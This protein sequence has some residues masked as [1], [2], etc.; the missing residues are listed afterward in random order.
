MTAHFA[1]QGILGTVPVCIFLGSLLYVDSYKLV[2]LSRVLQL[3]AAGGAA[4]ALSY[5]INRQIL[6]GAL[7]DR[8]MLTRFVAPAIEEALKFLP[9]LLMLRSKRLGFVID[10][11]ICGF[12]A[13]AGFAVIENLYYLSA[14]SGRGI[15]FWIVRGF[16]T[17]VMH[18]GTTAIAAMLTKTLQQRRESDSIV[19]AL[20][21][22]LLAF[23]IHALFNQ[24]YLSPLVSAVV[25]ILVLPPLMVLLF[26]V[27]ERH[28]Q[29]WIGTGFDRDAALLEAIRSD[30]FASSRHGRYLQSLREHFDGPVVADM[31]CYLRLYSELS[32]RAKGVLMLRENGLPVLPDA[33]TG[34]KLAELRYLRAAI[35]RTGQLAISPLLHRRDEDLW[36]LELLD[37]PS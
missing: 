6:E 32:I 15:P 29:A 8:Q 33:A 11:A 7:A 23:T 34:A 37:S 30:D 3:I 28:L 2:R 17:A 22:L 27:S 25:V 35:G 9:L 14:I 13:G 26:A 5:L 31:L 16:G 10:A 24:F 18:G 36:Q 1:L 19:L 21:G 4:A 12:A 20:P